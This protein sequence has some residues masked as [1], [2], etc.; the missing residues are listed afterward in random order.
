MTLITKLKEF[1]ARHKITTAIMEGAAAFTAVNAGAVALEELTKVETPIIETAQADY[2]DGCRGPNMFQLD[3]RITLSETPG[4][5]LLPKVFVDKNK[6]GHGF[7]G[8]TPFMYT[9]GQK[10]AVG[11]GA[12]MFV[13]LGKYAKMLGVVPVVYNAE[14]EAV[15]INPTVYATI[16]AGKVLVDPRVSYLASFAK[17]DT[18]HNLSFGTTLGVM[19][20]NVIIGGDVETSFDPSNA[21]SEQL[22]KNLKYGGIIRVDLDPQHKNWVQ[23]YFNNN[24]LTV[25][26]RANF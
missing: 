1:R 10:P 6:D 19:I 14:G 24:S 17:G 22:E 11:A 26:F 5:T 2:F 13:D 23:A 20:D 18:T 25:G 12:G 4:Y 21:Q 8:V 9:P 3:Q 7:F 16:M 15:N